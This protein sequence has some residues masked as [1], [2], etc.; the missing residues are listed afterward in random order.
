MFFNKVVLPMPFCPI[1]KYFKPAFIAISD[2]CIKVF[3]FISINIFSEYN[4]VK[5]FD[6]FF[7]FCSLFSFLFLFLFCLV[8]L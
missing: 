8:I 1:M 5:L 4:V 7:S 6:C 2:S 3:P